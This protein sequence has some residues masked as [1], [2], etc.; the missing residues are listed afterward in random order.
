GGSDTK[1]GNGGGQEEAHG[2]RFRKCATP[3]ANE[4]VRIAAELRKR[5]LY[6]RRTPPPALS[7]SKGRP[8]AP[9]VVRQ[10]RH[11]VGE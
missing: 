7:L 5:H 1:D 9:F 6:L 3:R 2:A 4:E 8:D 11:V 10:A